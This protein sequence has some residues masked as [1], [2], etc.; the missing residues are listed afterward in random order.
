VERRRRKRDEGGEERKVKVSFGRHWTKE[1][2]RTYEGVPPS[3]NT[4]ED[5]L[6]LLRDD[7]VEE[8]APS[9]RPHVPDDNALFLRP[10]RLTTDDLDRHMFAR[11]GGHDL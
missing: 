4:L 6:T 2:G 7:N 8:V 1:G 11:V 5:L 3:R 9:E 10:I